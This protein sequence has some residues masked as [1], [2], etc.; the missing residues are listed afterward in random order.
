LQIRYHVRD[1]IGISIELG[2]LGDVYLASGNNELAE[3][4]LKEAFGISTRQGDLEGVMEV[5]HSLSLLYEDEN[6]KDL[7][8]TYFKEFINARD[9]I[10]SEEFKREALIK[11]MEFKFDEEEQKIAI[12]TAAEKKR[13]QLYT[14]MVL[15]ILLIVV[16]FSL[17]LYKRFN[18]TKKQKSII[19]EQKKIV[20]EKQ[21]AITDSI[22]YAKRIQT[23]LMPTE[24]FIEKTMDVLK[25]KSK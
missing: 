10:K 23:T 24:K 22:H 4:Y 7:A 18:L 2:N 20:E 11:E 6:K 15:V 1:S 16:V 9:T 14:Y 21:K 12:E 5:G 19:E 25:G 13:Q 3:K 8:Y 17:L